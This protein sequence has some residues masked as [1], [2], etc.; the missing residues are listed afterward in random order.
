MVRRVAAEAPGSP[1]VPFRRPA[2][3][4]RLPLL[5]AALGPAFLL[6]YLITVFLPGTFNLGP[7]RLSL[8]KLV[9]LVAFVPLALQWVRSLRERIL[10]PDLLFL[11]FC[12]WVSLAT[13]AVHGAAQIF[14]IGSTFVEYFGAY[15]VGRIVIRNADDYAR[16][17]RYFLGILLVMAPF[18]II[19]AVTRVRLL[20]NIM[21]MVLSTADQ[22]V[23]EN[24]PRLGLTRATVG[25]NHPILWG[26]VCGLGFANVY[27]LYRDRFLRQIQ[28]VALVGLM[29]FLSISSGPLL[30]LGLQGLM[31]IWDHAFR[32]IRSRWLIGTV[33]GGTTLV[34]LQI[35]LPGGI[36]GYT[37]NEVIFSQ[38]S[39][40]TRITAFEYGTAE[41]L[42]SPFFG[43]GLKEYLRPWWEHSSIDNFWLVIAVRHGL[44]AL[45]L[46]VLSIGV[47]AALIMA[48]PD[49]DERESRCRTGYLI[50]LVALVLALITVHIWSNALAFVMTYIGAG[51]WFYAGS[52]PG[53]ETRRM[54]QGRAAPASGK[55]GPG[56]PMPPVVRRRSP[57][58]AAPALP[59]SGPARG[60]RPH[61]AG[62]AGINRTGRRG[63]GMPPA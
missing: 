21:G 56:R 37:V 26:I 13:Y 41:V 5:E 23:H 43:I 59:G 24:R 28:A 36:V 45:I 33:I 62:T 3:S 27:Y 53:R 4:R 50:A 7:I 16:M 57:G 29:T 11:G 20:S 61:P 12:L 42:R 38:Y 30:A 54:Q 6:L 46:L 17:F 55:G 34:V 35:I 44:P 58:T 2:P 31:I 39:G 51:A 25:F 18:A 19:E 8:F 1:S 52:R 14:Y 22:Y 47:S 49:L 15:L 48:Q 60:M 40:L 32:V 9:L 10:L 63:S